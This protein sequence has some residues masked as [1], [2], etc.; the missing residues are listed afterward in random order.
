ML[1]QSPASFFGSRV[2]MAA[3]F[4]PLS[5]RAPSKWV[6]P[7]KPM[8]I[9]PMRIMY[10]GPGRKCVEVRDDGQREWDLQ[11]TRQCQQA[12]MSMAKNLGPGDRQWNADA[13][14][15]CVCPGCFCLIGPAQPA[16][17]LK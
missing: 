10:A 7:I 16:N 17:S 14:R 3:T 12:R 5:L 8:P 13:D 4:A 1:V 15:P 2:A 11:V 9:M 6:M